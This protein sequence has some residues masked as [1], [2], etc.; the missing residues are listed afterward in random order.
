MLY[1]LHFNIYIIN[2]RLSQF[3]LS[4]QKY[5]RRNNCDKNNDSTTNITNSL[6]DLSCN[7]IDNN[8]FD[9]VGDEYDQSAVDKPYLIKY[10]DIF[11]R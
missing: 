10:S 11:G 2:F 4:L 5:K 3:F 8:I 7:E 1:I 9:E 6:A